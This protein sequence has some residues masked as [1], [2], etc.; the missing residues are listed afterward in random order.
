[1]SFAYM[2][3]PSFKNLPES[4]STPAVLELSIFV[5]IFKTFSSEVLLKQKSSK[6][7]KLEY[8]LITD[9]K[10]HLSWGLWKL[11]QERLLKKKFLKILEIERVSLSCIIFFNCI[12]IRNYRFV[13]YT[14]RFKG[15]P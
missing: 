3:A 14:Q 8:Y 7:A 6:F 4:L 15:F 13:C 11:N 2:L 12:E 9:C 5:I 1:M 10:L